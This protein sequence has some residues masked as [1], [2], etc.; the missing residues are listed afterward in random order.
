VSTSPRGATA[1]PVIPQLLTI[2]E[3]CHALRVARSTLYRLLDA[4][5]LRAVKIGGSRRIPATEIERIATGG[6][7]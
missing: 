4:G 2:P 7:A 1:A 5:D 6:A 3:A